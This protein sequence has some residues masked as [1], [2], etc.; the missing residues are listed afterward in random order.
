M[1][2][3][4]RGRGRGARGCGRGRVAQRGSSTGRGRRAQGRGRRCGQRVRGTLGRGQ[5]VQ[6]REPA[7]QSDTN[8]FE[9]EAYDDMDQR[10]SGILVDTDGFSPVDYFM[11]FFPEAAF[12]LIVEETNQYALNFFD[13]PA[14]LPP[15]SRFNHW[16]DTS[17]EEIKA[18]VGLEIAMGLCQKNSIEDYWETFHLTHTP[19]TDVMPRNRFELISSFLH[20][21]DNSIDRPERGHDNYDA[22]WK[23]RP[24]IDIC[25][26]TYLAVYTPERNIAIDESIVRFKGRIAFRQYLPNK[27]IRWGIKQYA[28]CESR[29]GYALKFITYCGKGTLHTREGFTLTESL[30]LDLLDGFQHFGH[31]VYTDNYYSSPKLFR[32]LQE[33]GIAACGTVK[34]G[35]QNMPREIHP[36]NLQL[37]KGDDPVFMKSGDMIACAWHDTKR[38]HFLSTMHTNNTI[39]KQIRSRG[40]PGGH[41]EV[42]KP[43]CAEVYNQNMGGVDLLDQKLGTFAFPHKV[44]KWYHSVYHRIREVALVNVYIIYT[45]DKEAKE[46]KAVLPRA[47][48][49]QVVDGLISGFSSTKT[50]RGRPIKGDVPQRLTERHSIGMIEKK[51]YRPDCIVCS[52]RTK[53]GWKRKQTTYIC[54]QCNKAM[55]AYP[56][57]KLY[58]FHKDYRKAAA[59]IVHGLQ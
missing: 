32:Q 5:T 48:R 57:H 3:G 24:L 44:S 50:R 37:D 58:H 36:K 20:F 38:V 11:L 55:C 27:P 17:V 31:C 33:D 35:R 29:S 23:I 13:N 49:Q 39:N 10:R 47:F 19:F 34:A 21:S 26:P 1:Q 45:K 6:H 53:P 54:K 59:Q 15:H 56:C 9:W 28:L 43:V 46:E 30:C 16:V 40:A 2:G 8:R 51:G 14:P 42:E 7:D 4:K 12:E 22:L 18:Y 41:R 25:E 52:D